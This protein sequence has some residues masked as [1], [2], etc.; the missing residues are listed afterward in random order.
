V[1][2]EKQD[3]IEERNEAKKMFTGRESRAN[4]LDGR[5][6]GLLKWQ[7]KFTNARKETEEAERKLAVEE[8][9][10]KTAKEQSK[11]SEG[12]ERCSS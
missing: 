2:K 11:D 3:A 10:T 6:A 4:S 1:Q 5:V 8:Q 12:G 9:Q 7:G